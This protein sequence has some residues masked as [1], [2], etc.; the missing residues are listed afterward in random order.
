MKGELMLCM[1]KNASHLGRYLNFFE[2]T[3]FEFRHALADA[4]F[5]GGVPDPAR[6]SG[7]ANVRRTRRQ[8]FGVVLHHALEPRGL[9]E[10]GLGSVGVLGVHELFHHALGPLQGRD[11]GLQLHDQLVDVAL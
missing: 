3:H 2:F 11:I 1:Q 8:H 10:G 9:L 4:V 6:R 7:E 5:G